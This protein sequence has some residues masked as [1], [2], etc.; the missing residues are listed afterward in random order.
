MTQAGE[1]SLPGVF[2]LRHL[3]AC[4]LRLPVSTHPF[5]T[6]VGPQVN[7]LSAAFGGATSVWEGLKQ[8]GLR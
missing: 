2:E 6:Q 3:M 5:L 8:R 1:S 7:W 4:V